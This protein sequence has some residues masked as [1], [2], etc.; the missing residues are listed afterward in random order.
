MRL[1]G[2]VGA[3][4]LDKMENV[5]RW[6]TEKSQAD[7]PI[8]ASRGCREHVNAV[9]D[10]SSMLDPFLRGFVEELKKKCDVTLGTAEAGQHVDERDSCGLRND[11]SDYNSTTT[12]SPANCW[13]RVMCRRRETLQLSSST[14]SIKRNTTRPYDP[15]WTAQ[16]KIV[17]G[18]RIRKKRKMNILD[19]SRAHIYPSAKRSVFIEL[20]Q[21][22]MTKKV[23]LV[24][25]CVHS[26]VEETQDGQG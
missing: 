17:D 3:S 14:T 22:V 15:R 10:K 2:S 12:R 13:I 5:K 1:Y 11:V 23:A 9:D 19:V 24:D 7:C 18:L 6:I 26:T 25:C 21:K 16:Y 4:Q 8:F 20:L